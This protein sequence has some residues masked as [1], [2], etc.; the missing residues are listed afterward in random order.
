VRIDQAVLPGL[1]PGFEQ[2][3][4][5]INAPKPAEGTVVLA[6]WLNADGDD[7]GHVAATLGEG[8]LYFSH[9]IVAE[10]AADQAAAGRMLG[11]VARS[12]TTQRGRRRDIAIVYGTASEATG[13]GD[14]R[15]V[16]ETVEQMEDI[17]EAAGL[18]HTIVT[19]EAVARGAL[20][21]RKLA[22]FPLNFRLVPGEAEAVRRFV[23]AGGKVF[24]CFS[25]AEELRPLMGVGAARFRAG[26]SERPFEMVRFNSS[27]PDAM[28]RQFAQGAA[29]TFEAE[30]AE[31]GTVLGNW[32]N[33]TGDDSGVPAVIM[34]PTGLYFA[35]LLRPGDITDTSH[36]L[37]AAIAEM[38]GP[39]VYEP[40]LAKA[41]GGLWKF[42]RFSGRDALLAACAGDARATEAAR[43]A[44]A[45]EERAAGEQADGRPGEAYVTLAE[46]RRVAET[47][48]IR[49]LP[50]RPG[51]ELRAAWMHDVRVPGQQWDRFFA[52]M[53]ELNIN[54]FLPNVCAA[55]YAHYDSELLPLSPFI[56]ENGPQMENMLA[57]AKRHGIEIHLWRVNYNLWWPGRETVDRLAAEN[58]L[59]L[60]PE[61][62]KVG[63]GPGTGSLCPSHPE[64]KRLEIEAMVEMTRKFHPDGIH[65]DY[66]RYP[67]GDACF[68]S[69][70]RTRFEDRIGQAV[71]NWPVDVL[72]DGRWRQ[73]Y[74][75]FR[76]DQ[77]TDVVAEVS[78]RSREIDPDVL[79]SAAVFS[80]WERWARDSIGQDWPLWVE[81]GYL[82]FVCPMNYT[83]DVEDLGRVVSDQRRWVGPGFQLISGIGAFRSQA[84]WHTADLVDTARTNGASGLC[85]FDYRGR[86]VTTLLPALLEGPFRDPAQTPWGR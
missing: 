42:R 25:V 81:R 27:A 14:G 22:I 3:S 43:Q 45:L 82:D 33:S 70:C 80:E 54:A 68:C 78:R 63:R 79:I 1:P 75:D 29:N 64:N 37:L 76:R 40:A 56:R 52:R 86:T 8:G 16:G 17:L 12:L 74:L 4:W 47:A 24:G 31:D 5:N 44:A 30:P 57:A 11:A 72:G 62:N 50:C 36:F 55:G 59:C 51:P 34:S 18:E 32:H 26:G 69:G 46:A 15:L 23:A 73:Q 71:E 13:Q 85:F 39:E 38:I 53:R 21:D 9:V 65:F 41:R 84:P 49:S 20:R 2:V 83:Q 60:D 10:G 35:Y 48:F 7:T 28:P 66:I 67:G 6:R 61:G 58:R 77:I 19:D